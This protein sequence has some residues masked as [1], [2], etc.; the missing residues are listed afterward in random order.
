MIDDV[1]YDDKKEK[2]L[3]LHNVIAE[4]VALTDEALLEKFFGG[5]TLSMEEIHRGLHA[6]VISGEIAPVLV[7]SA[8]KDIGILTM[9]EM[10][11]DYMPNPAELKPYA[12]FDKDGKELIRKTIP[13]EPFSA[14]VFNTFFF[15]RN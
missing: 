6:A 8:K 1:I 5:E 7:G 10:L 2:I 14:Y 12:G 13:S 3:S 15:T 11:I 4:Q 9:L